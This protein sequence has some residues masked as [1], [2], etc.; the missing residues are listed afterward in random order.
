[1]LGVDRGCAAFCGDATGVSSLL[2]EKMYGG[3]GVKLD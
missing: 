3:G 1:M 2:D